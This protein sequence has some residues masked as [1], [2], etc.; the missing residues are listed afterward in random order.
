MR[1]KRNY[2]INTI[3]TLNSSMDHVNGHV[4]CVVV[5]EPAISWGYRKVKSALIPDGCIPVLDD[6][7]TY[8]LNLDGTNLT[9][10]DYTP[11]D[12]TDQTPQDCFEAQCWDDLERI[13]RLSNNTVEKI[14]LGVFIALAICL[15]IVLFLIS[16]MAMG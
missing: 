6:G 15:V 2:P 10:I 11:T 4:N 14:K 9:S 3:E 5:N 16:V 12:N 13:V 7:L 1:R 8:L